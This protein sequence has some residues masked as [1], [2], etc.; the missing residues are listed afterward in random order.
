M[1]LRLGVPNAGL[2]KVDLATVVA[3]GDGRFAA[4][5]TLPE[6][7]PGTDDPVVERDLVLAVVDLVRAETLTVA[8]LRNSAADA[9]HQGGSTD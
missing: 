1:A 3:D 5:V 8:P 2:G 9:A 4:T 7:W 6:T